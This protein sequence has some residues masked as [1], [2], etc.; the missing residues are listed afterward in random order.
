MIDNVYLVCYCDGKLTSLGQ[1][2]FY[3]LHIVC[4][5]L[6]EEVTFPIILNRF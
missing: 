5:S 1:E 6:L 4:S 2:T 3:I